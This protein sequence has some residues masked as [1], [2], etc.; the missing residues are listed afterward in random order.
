MKEP[1]IP[2]LCQDCLR[3][4][5]IET[6][7]HDSGDDRACECG[8]QVCGCGNCMATYARLLNGCRDKEKLRLEGPAI[9]FEWSPHGGLKVGAG[10]TA[11]D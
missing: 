6:A 4:V 7:K 10:Q 2:A 9:E 11:N 3:I 8:G 1:M 5:I